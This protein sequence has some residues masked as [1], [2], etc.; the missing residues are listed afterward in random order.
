MVYAVAPRCTA[1]IDS[2]VSIT[3]ALL[4]PPPPCATSCINLALVQLCLLSKAVDSAAL[5][6]NNTTDGTP[7][8]SW[9]T[10]SGAGNIRSIVLPAGYGLGAQ[11]RACS[12]IGDCL[13]AVGADGENIDAVD[14][15]VYV[16]PVRS[17]T[18][19]DNLIVVAP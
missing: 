18:N 11:T 10:V 5:N 2:N 16:K 12:S 7:A 1:K 15:Y 19:N 8:G 3:I 9:L 6:C 17:S 4:A 14:N 13:E